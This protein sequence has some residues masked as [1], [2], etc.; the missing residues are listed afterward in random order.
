[1]LLTTEFTGANVFA[2]VGT[3][4]FHL[5]PRATWRHRTL[6]W[7]HVQ[8]SFCPAARTRSTARWQS[9]ALAGEALIE[10]QHLTALIEP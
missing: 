3:K 6:K 9:P 7:G 1:V 2:L 5:L 4:V 8:S 10:P